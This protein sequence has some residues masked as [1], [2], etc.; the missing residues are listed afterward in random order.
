MS[1]D[2]QQLELQKNTFYRDNYRRTLKLVVLMALVAVGLTVVLFYVSLERK[3]PNYYATTTSGV[4]IPMHALTQPV[5][6]NHYILR[7]AGLAMRT[8]FNIG[9]VDANAN[10]QKAK[11]Y[12][13]EGGWSSFQK[14]VKQAGL[15]KAV[16][17]QKLL[18]SAV[19]SG[20]P[21][22]IDQGV[23]HGK[24]TW[25]IQLPVLATFTSAS[26]TLHRKL[27]V[28]MVVKR[29]SVMASANGIQIVDFETQGM[30]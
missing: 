2:T 17:N 25:T 4:I 8:A 28:T 1:N 30:E 22:I 9:F 6:T 7:W 18:M 21:L 27:L 26:Q 3:Q 13:T 23:K 14:A 15:L 20:A 24:Y 16:V 12:F 11:P 29:T 19:V 10:M 5:V